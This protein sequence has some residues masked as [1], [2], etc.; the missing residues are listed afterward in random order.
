[1]LINEN[2]KF[3]FFNRGLAIACLNINSLTAHIDELRVFM[4]ASKIDILAINES[5]LDKTINDHEVY[6]PG[7]EIVRRDRQINGRKGGGVCFYLRS[8]LNFKVCE[9]LMID[10]LECLTVEISKPHSRPFLVSTWYKP[11]NSPPDLFNDFENLIGEID[12]SNRELY[13]VGDMNT[14]LLPGVAESNSSKLINVCE[15][16]GLR[17]LITEPTRVTTQS[18]SLIDLCITNTPDKIVRSGVLPLG[19]SDHSLVYLIRKTHYTIPG[20][21][22]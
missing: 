22:K 21:V 14:K 16:F 8:N 15:I 17:Q 19:I 11:P 13:L 7:Y 20:C 12:G 2:R 18:Q 4:R 5:K 6:I 1:M 9:E 10:R 3:N